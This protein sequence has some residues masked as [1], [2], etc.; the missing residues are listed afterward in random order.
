MRAGTGWPSFSD[1]LPKAVK[2]E[3]DY[4]IP[5]MPRTEVGVGEAGGQIRMWFASQPAC[6]FYVQSG[7]G[8][9]RL[10]LA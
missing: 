1:A 8:I 5:F 2:L 9:E 6:L 7:S 10:R 4:S 3:A